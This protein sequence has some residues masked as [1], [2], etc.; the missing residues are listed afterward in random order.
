MSGKVI[1]GARLGRKLGFPTANIELHRR[2]T[3]IQGIFAARVTGGG[4]VEAAAVT[5]LG[6]RPVVNG[7]EP[8]LEAHVFDFDGDLYG[9]YLHVDFVE[10]LRDEANF[11]N[12]DALVVQM[13]D[14][15][16]RARAALSC[17]THDSRITDH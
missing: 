13:N 4:L 15:A 10:R 11:P 9:E 8:L 17:S 7:T 16:R 14:D 12:L 2:V 6:T 5:N 3:P 1:G